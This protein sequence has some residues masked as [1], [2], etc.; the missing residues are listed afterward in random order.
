MSQEALRMAGYEGDSP[1]ALLCMRDDMPLETIK[2][3]VEQNRQAFLTVDTLFGYTPLHGA[4]EY[5]RSMEIISLL[6]N[7]LQEILS[8]KTEEIDYRDG[9]RC[10]PLH[11]LLSRGANGSRQQLLKLFR[12]LS[13]A[14]RRR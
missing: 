14:F 6:V 2:V 12:W 11:C 3:L 8:R 7:M 4:C 10:T 5:G 1:L 9:G 13:I